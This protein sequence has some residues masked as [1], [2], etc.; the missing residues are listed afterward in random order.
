MVGAGR[1]FDGLVVTGV[2]LAGAVV[3]R[4]AEPLF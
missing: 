4:V 3:T 2:V 1:V